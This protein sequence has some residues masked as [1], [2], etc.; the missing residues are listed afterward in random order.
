MYPIISN[1]LF[2]KSL[3]SPFSAEKYFK[4]CDGWTEWKKKKDTVQFQYEA[5]S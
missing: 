3:T 2:I 5:G 4:T 1:A